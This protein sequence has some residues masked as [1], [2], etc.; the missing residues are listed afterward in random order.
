M[1][2][3]WWIVMCGAIVVL[4]LWSPRAEAALPRTVDEFRQRVADDARD[5][6][7][8]M[9]LFFE[10]LFVY[11]SPDAD[12]SAAGGQMIDLIC[13]DERWRR[14]DLFLSQLRHKPYIFRSY[15][16]G[17]SP[18]NDY[19]MDPDN[20]ELLFGRLLDERER[21]CILE[22]RSTGASRVRPVR[23]IRRDGHWWVQGYGNLYEGVTPPQHGG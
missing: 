7:G 21:E 16:R 8:A 23:L 4:G 3:R 2:R 10:A 13:A 9:H 19:R 18:E 6:Q 11:L 5:P 15:C 17:T 14:N 20:F 22:M 12:R 1:R